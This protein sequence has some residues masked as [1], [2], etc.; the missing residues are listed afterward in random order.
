MIMNNH[1]SPFN[2]FIYEET[3]LV[4]QLFKEIVF[5]LLLIDLEIFTWCIMN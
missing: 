1:K 2:K 5:K 4:F 3:K